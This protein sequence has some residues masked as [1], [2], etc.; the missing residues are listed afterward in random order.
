MTISYYG[1]TPGRHSTSFNSWIA[2][3]CKNGNNALLQAGGQS[4][5]WVTIPAIPQ[6]T[7]T[8]ISILPVASLQVLPQNQESL[9][10]NQD[11][12]MNKISAVNSVAKSTENVLTRLIEV[13]SKNLELNLDF[14]LVCKRIGLEWKWKAELKL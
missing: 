9:A 10:T 1:N 2:L 8:T 11:S 12:S 4:S 14:A 7:L 3:N 5:N 13:L 6:P